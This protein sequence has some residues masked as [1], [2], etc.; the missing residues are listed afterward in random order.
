MSKLTEGRRK[1]QPI[2]E[3]HDGTNIRASRISVAVYR[4]LLNAKGK[5]STVEVGKATGHPQSSVSHILTNWN[6]GGLVSCVYIGNRAWWKWQPKA[7]A[8]ES[9]AMLED[10][11]AVCD[12][13]PEPVSSKVSR[14]TAAT[15]AGGD[16]VAQ[17]ARG[18]AALL[19][20][21]ADRLERK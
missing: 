18:L 13:N 12:A 6:R 17:L 10:A 20:E 21:A 5:M 3:R 19:I 9:V 8:K 15:P 7:S 14:E 1:G 11:A 16:A 2:A 4:V